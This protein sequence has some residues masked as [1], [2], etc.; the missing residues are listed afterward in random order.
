M[1]GLF[2]FVD[3]TCF[4]QPLQNSLNN[5]LVPITDCLS[6]LIVL[7]IKF[8]PEINKLLRD[9]FDEFSRWNAGF[10][11]RSLDLLAVLI[12]T[13]QKE[14]VFALE[15]MIASNHIGKHLFVG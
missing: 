7:D 8:F 2:I 3:L 4:K 6:P 15:P 9:F 13:G 10:S 12:N 1:A 11:C 14:N 5:F